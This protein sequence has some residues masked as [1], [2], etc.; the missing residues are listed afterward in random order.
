VTDDVTEDKA[1]TVRWESAK[2]PRIGVTQD[3]RVIVTDAEGATV[4][5]SEDEQRRIAEH[6]YRHRK[7]EA[8]KAATTRREYRAAARLREPT[9]LG[10]A[11][12][13]RHDLDGVPWWR[14]VLHYL[15]WWP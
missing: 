13:Y 4:T 3:G 7:H 6:Y 9:R 5:L 10:W 15:G 1:D 11:C 2:A 12:D 14:R 8:I